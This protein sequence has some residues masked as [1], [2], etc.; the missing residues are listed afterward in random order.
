MAKSYKYI[1]PYF[2]KKWQQWLTYTAAPH[3]SIVPAS[4]IVN[5]D[6]ILTVYCASPVFHAFGNGQNVDLH[7]V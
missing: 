7:M 4:Q 2:K 6:D 1:L 5:T 3:F